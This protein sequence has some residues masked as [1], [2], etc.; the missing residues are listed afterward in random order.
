MWQNRVAVLGV[1]FCLACCAPAGAQ[2]TDKY[3]VELP[4]NLF[5]PVEDD[6]GGIRCG[7]VRLSPE[8]DVSHIYDSNPEFKTPDDSKPQ[9]FLRVRPMLDLLVAGNGWSVDGKGWMSRDWLMGSAPKQTENTLKNTQYGQSLAAVVETARETKF[10][11]NELFQFS[12]RNNMVATTVPGQN[13]SWQDRYNLTLGAGVATPLGEK[14]GV[15]LGGS[16]EDVWYDSGSQYGYSAVGTTLGFTRQLTEKSDAMLDFGYKNQQ[17]ENG[18]GNSSEYSA[19]A[20]FGS[21]VTEKTSYR[22]QGGMMLYSFDGGNETA[23][24]PTY[25]LL[26]T[27]QIA[28]RLMADVSGGGTYQP[29]ES[30]SNNYLVSHT[31]GAGLNFAATSRLSTGLHAIYRR[32]QYGK[33]DVAT[34]DKRLD[35]RVSLQARADYKLTKYATLYMLA[36]ATDNCSNIDTV[37]YQR[38]TVQT[39]VNL[40]F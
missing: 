1:G 20:G 11:L 5:A 24:A 28:P 29:T 39:G 3:D 30:E 14:T 40:K 2:Q 31:L 9:N 23:I 36:E 7:K 32:E 16:Y 6:V 4:D 33:A 22:A 15:K 13:A 8:L 35:D 27:W 26:G 17:S 12:D 21:R 34:G 19:L 18:S 10:T 38:L 25:S 37:E